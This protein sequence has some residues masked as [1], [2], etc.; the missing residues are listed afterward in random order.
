MTS[1]P[2]DIRA[3]LQIIN[4][5]K[6]FLIIPLIVAI[7]GAYFH[8]ATIVPVYES[9]AS[10]LLGR[11]TYITSTMSRV[12]P[13]VQA[14]NR[15]QLWRRRQTIM[16][17]VY[18]TTMMQKVIDRAGLEPTQG[19]IEK[20]KKLAK[21]NPNMKF[22]D[23]LRMVQVNSLMKRV[24]VNIP[25]RGEY[26]EIGAKS[27][28]PRKAYLIAKT[29]ADL[30]IEESLLQELS[31]VQQT[32]QFS[33]EQLEVYRKKLEEAEKKL[34]D[35]RRNM[36]RETN[37]EL[38][39]TTENLPQVRS[40]IASIDVDL[41]DKYDELNNI[42]RQ[43]GGLTSAI[44][45][46]KT[47]KATML[48]A[49][50]IEKISKLAELM[51]TFSWNS[52]EVLSL[53]QEIVALKDELAEEIRKHSAEGLMGRYNEA[54]IQRAV[55][56]EIILNE[57]DLL[58]QQKKTLE[59]ILTIYQN[60]QSKIPAYELTLQKLQN[61]VSKNREIYQAFL[62]QVQSMKIREAMQ[63]TEAQILFRILEPAQIPVVPVNTDVRKILILAIMAGL[64]VGGGL[65]YLLEMMD[66]SFKDVDDVEKYLGLI[67]VGTVP[68]MNFGDP[69]P[70]RRRW[71]V[72]V[73]AASVIIIA[74]IGFVL[75][76]RG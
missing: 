1:S 63:H 22:E 6:W 71:A 75:L 7:V 64:G 57:I 15:Q 11:N 47:D 40:L 51:I 26:F 41:T 76:N 59:Q 49:R 3:I 53:N 36:A 35:F 17:Q 48:K 58:K 23:I 16:K 8:I 9:K 50:L 66:N 30:F 68:K 33:N 13:G 24:I 70:R 28:N 43:L 12:L 52:K 45:L 55:Q 34:R 62:E 29:L 20:A 19:Q 60:K 4:R 27:T 10:I 31:G 54:D 46:L 74:L 42:E 14:Q 2:I 32:L 21:E 44:R 61:E 37:V 39:I 72:P 56:R 5:R 25:R 18:N 38:P 73:V 67:V 65:V 69:E